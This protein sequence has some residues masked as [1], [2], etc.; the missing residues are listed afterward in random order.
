MSHKNSA[1]SFIIVNYNSIDSLK[2]CLDDLATIE[3]ANDFEVIIINNESRP[4]SL[5]PHSFR[6]QQIYEV[7]H[8]IG[9]GKASNIGLKIAT[10]PYVCFL[11][12]DT[13][14][15]C[16]D[17]AKIT[18]MITHEKMIVAPQIRTESNEREP[19]SVGEDVNLMQIIKNNCGINKKMWLSDKNTKVAWA[20]GAALFAQ[21]QFIKHLG[22]FDEDFFLYFEDV[23]LCKRARNMGGEIYYIP[24]FFLTH[25]RGIS[26]KNSI[27]KQKK[28][29][30][31]SQ[32]LF[33]QKHVG[34]MQAR[35]MR[36]LR[37]ISIK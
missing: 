21:T 23:D 12:P 15:F 20:S 2:H 30:Y 28:W 3:N 1:I 4:I 31:K 19:W 32:D 18:K 17:L 22:G 7:G 37:S 11:N 9:Y 36:T 33:F 16:N 6:R 10:H 8:N 13:H 25:T 27:Q 26:T 29:Y 24:R 35:I 5:P 34:A 14:S